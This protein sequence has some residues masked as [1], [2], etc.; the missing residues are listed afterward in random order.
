M[1][2]SLELVELS[3]NERWMGLIGSDSTVFVAV[4]C[5]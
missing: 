5:V 2:D 4:R 1:S 3:C